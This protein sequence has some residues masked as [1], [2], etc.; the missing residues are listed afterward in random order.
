MSTSTPH[1]TDENEI[2]AKSLDSQTEAINQEKTSADGTESDNQSEKDKAI[3]FKTLL[4]IKQLEGKVAEYEKK[5]SDIREYVKKMEDEVQQIK[6][7]TERD[8]QKNLDQKIGNF[9]LGLLR[10]VDDFERCLK[11]S[12]SETGP[13]LEGV[14]LIHQHFSDFLQKADLQRI[15]TKGESFDPLLH[16]AIVSQ[17]VSTQD[18]DGKILE[19]LQAGYRYKNVVIRTAQVMVG[20]FSDAKEDLH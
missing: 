12:A 6:L 19:E 16:E 10:V 11:S 17:P 15:S 8:S 7:R 9:F 14:K 1:N 5:I 2:D 18:L 3:D 4:H 13:L 20:Q